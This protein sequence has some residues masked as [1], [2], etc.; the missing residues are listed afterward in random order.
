MVPII[1]KIVDREGKILWEYIPEPK[2]VLPERV[3]ILT[4]EI[5]RKVMEQ[6]TGKKARDVVRVF[7]IPL[8]SFGKTGTANRYTNSSFVG[9]IPGP[10]N[11]TGQLAIENG[12]TIASYVG[13]DNNRPMKGDHMAL[14]GSSGALP[15]W[16]DAAKAIAKTEDFKQ[17]LQPADLAFNPLLR[18]VTPRKFALHPVPVSPETGLPLKNG[19]K[20]SHPS[21]LPEVLTQTNDGGKTWVLKREFEIF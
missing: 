4:S 21:A 16:M 5:L 3:T 20:P 12:Y 17:A 14:Y 2:V 11:T 9:L 1:K 13:F 7:D 18:P 10:D 15:L 6:G 8:P 19:E